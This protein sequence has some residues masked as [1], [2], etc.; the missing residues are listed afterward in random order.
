MNNTIELSA[1]APLKILVVDDER[2]NCA[3]VQAMLGKMGHQT[4]LAHNGKEGVE[5]VIQHHPDLVLMDVRMPEMDGYEAVRALR[6]LSEGQ[7]PIIFLTTLNA[8]EDII[9]GLNAG[10]DDYLHKPLHFE[11]LKA[12]IKTVYER[13]WLLSNLA[14]Q[15]QLLLEHKERLDE[16]RK[17]AVRFAN[18]LSARDQLSD[19][20][21]NFFMKHAEDFG[22]DLVAAARTPDGHIHALLTD[23]AGHG[24]GAA[25]SIFPLVRPFYTM[26]SRGLDISVIIG[27]L[28]KLVKE[29]T[30]LPNYVTA[31][32]VSMNPR[33]GI[34]EV[35]NGGSPDAILVAE[36][37]GI[38]KR[39][40]SSH[41]PLGIL[42]ERQFDDAKERFDFG[43]QR[44]KL[45]LYSDGLTELSERDG[46]PIELE[47]I[48][49]EYRFDGFGFQK[50]VESIE[51]AVGG[52]Q[53]SDDIALM[54]IDL[55][56]DQDPVAFS[57]NEEAASKELMAKGDI[58][59]EI[60]GM[61]WQF[62]I[63]LTA[64]Q[65]KYLEVVPLLMNIT[66]AIGA[67]GTDAGAFMVLSELFN[68]A[69][70]HGVLKLDSALKHQDEGM[71]AYFEARVTRLEELKDAHIRICLA[72]VESSQ[73]NWLKMSVQDSGDGFDFEKYRRAK[74]EN[75]QRHGRGLTLVFGMCD[76]VEFLDNGRHVVAYLPWTP[77]AEKK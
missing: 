5:M 21:V 10:G 38:V 65:L 40:A 9:D 49:K 27:E 41:L 29:F 3:V 6:K 53:V 12:K 55:T 39:F 46:I 33:E 4:L 51:T 50:I 24:L 69:L 2:V 31:T 66:G 76:K 63:M 25:L 43:N 59:D 57:S 54:G 68:N 32:I 17:T 22:G 71:D 37:K 48:L 15:N 13:R 67:G 77:S 64:P 1:L 56:K 44:C 52:K 16:D 28:N 14:Q 11:L 7:L 30:T 34:I 23:S 61:A 75:N 73:G 62:D 36:G 35:W 42:S 45:F 26:T 19:H 72:H 18:R 20:A 70:D 58:A 60:S 47:S 74:L 8:A